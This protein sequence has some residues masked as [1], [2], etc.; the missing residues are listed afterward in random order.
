MRLFRAMLLLIAV[1][2]AVPTALLG[3]LLARTS[4]DQLVTDALELAS[5]RVER[6][7]LQ[8]EEVL[9][10]AA[11]ALEGT[12]RHSAWRELDLDAR[13]RAVAGLLLRRDELAVVTLFDGAGQKIPGVQAFTRGVAP[14]E[15]AEH[16]ARASELLAAGAVARGDEP[17]DAARFSPP[18]VAPHR[19]EV[20]VTVLVRVADPAVGAAAAEVSL[21]A[22]QSLVERTRAG[23]RGLAFVVD[24]AGRYVAHLR[25]EAVLDR[26]P[27]AELDVVRRIAR[28]LQEGSTAGVA[29]VAEFRGA[30]GEELLG[31][32]ALLPQL[33]WGVVVQQPRND[34]FAA[35]GRMQRT[36]LAGAAVSLL[37]ALALSAGFARSLT[38]PVAECVRGA[39]EIAAGRFGHEVKVAARNEIGELAY[40]F[41]HMS[42]ELRSYD[43]ENRRLIAAL[44][45]GYVDSLRSLASAIDAKD[46]YTRGHSQ[47]VADLAVEI[48]RELGCD[49]ATLKTLSYAGILHDIGKIGIAEPILRKKTHLTEEEMAVMRGHPTIGAEI[50]G[51]V[52]FLRQALPGIRWH[53]E[54]WD[55]NGYPD[56]LAG[57]DIPLLARIVNAADTF[58]ACTSNRPYQRAMSRAEVLEI[59]ARLRGT[60]MDPAVHDALLAALGRR[61]GAARSAE[62]AA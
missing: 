49:D 7:R 56:R 28:A 36:V 1:A 6:L 54:R 23:A 22:V 12:A 58:D 45:Q 4:R 52:E 35:V 14:S 37:L 60:Q 19:R 34:A 26:R 33:G 25:P 40:T 9:G 50:V 18:Y 44:E 30:S 8:V 41:N 15:L 13:R 24:G 51:N 38:R 3:V 53:H 42:R 39:L 57:A 59:V 10:D 5:E 31:A 48:G 61:S 29:Q 11:R 27:A 62:D 2:S 32:Y 16:E 20:V 47:R 17:A 55:G 43:A 46:P 21:R